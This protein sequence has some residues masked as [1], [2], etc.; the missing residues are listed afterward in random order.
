MI[1]FAAI[2]PPSGILGK[3]YSCIVINIKGPR[4]IKRKGIYYLF[5]SSWGRGYKVG[6]ATSTNI[7]GL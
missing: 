1:D 6:Y 7:K 4:V 2:Y 5:Y 3:W